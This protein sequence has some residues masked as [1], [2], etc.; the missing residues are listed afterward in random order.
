MAQRVAA[1]AVEHRGR[2]SRVAGWNRRAIVA[3]GCH[4]PA[5]SIVLCIAFYPPDDPVHS[6]PISVQPL[7]IVDSRRGARRGGRLPCAPALVIALLRVIQLV[8]TLSRQ[9]PQQTVTTFPAQPFGEVLAPCAPRPEYPRP[10]LRRETWTN[11]NGEW[12]FAYDDEDRGLPEGWA[13]IEAAAL[14]HATPFDLSITVPFCPQSRRS[15]IGDTG[16]HDIVWYAR[17]FDHV[18]T[19]PAQRVLLHFGAADY[20]TN[21]WV[22]G[23][24]VGH[25]E[26][27]HT[28]FTFDVT[29][30]LA[31]DENVLVVRVEDRGR[32]TTNPRGKQDWHE[33]PTHIHYNRTTGIWQTVWLEVVDALHI[34]DVRITPNVVDSCISV[35]VELSRALS[36]A[37]AEID[38][39]DH[40]HTLANAFLAVPDGLSH[41][42]G[43]IPL[44]E[45]PRPRF[46][47]PEDPHLYDIEIRI[48]T[49][50]GSPCDQVIGYFGLR[51][52]TVDAGRVLLNGA[53]IQ[54]RMVLDQGYWTD[55][56]MTAPSDAALR[57]D[58]VWAQSMGFNGAR[59]HQKIEDPRWLYW[60]DRLGFLV[61]EEM[62]GAPEFSGTSVERTVR[63]WM[64]V[65]SR[66][67]NHPC[68]ICWV[69]INE[70]VGC[71]R[72]GSDG[73]NQIGPF[74]AAYA[75][76]LYFLTKALDPSRLALSN[77]GWEHTYSD[78]CTIHDY[79]S[80]EALAHRFLDVNAALS[81]A[82]ERRPVYA[83]P[84]QH[85]GQP[86]L[87]T[88]FGGILSGP[89]DADFDY[90]RVV[91]SQDL[92]NAVRSMLAVAQ[93]SPILAG[94]C[95]T[96]LTD[97]E[98]ETNGLLTAARTPKVDVETIRTV[99]ESAE[100]NT[101]R[102]GAPRDA[103]V[104]RSK[105]E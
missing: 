24:F 83:P 89:A 18:N 20:R 29:D 2:A 85:D 79:R 99:L 87:L 105:K 17:R 32:D 73:R 16:F 74:E 90:L 88:E 14:D 36:G 41:V 35:Q 94:F 45:D 5:F 62:P 77:D 82:A 15:G 47:S 3:H 64:A 54:V 34:T 12:R 43:I 96:Q 63:E 69:P 31:A 21:V 80:R 30:A 22:N 26:G 78:L 10:Q 86:V 7:I 71:R 97:V 9:F 8:R 98:H 92:T 55:T 60:A 25:H 93:A 13:R 52:I 40:G 4:T 81:N 104:P 11:L 1:T 75:S 46:W 101:P 42:E 6:P 102:T 72:I 28:P 37:R 51:S 84:H 76:A 100:P 49:P 58:I 61:W 91:D 33:A 44:P 59:K 67:H 23:S 48:I 57:Q 95:Y 56:L 103:N 38:V 53:P 66:D 50:S 68:I 19:G 65:L 39:L 70:S 27:G